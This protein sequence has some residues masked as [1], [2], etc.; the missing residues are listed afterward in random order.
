[1]IQEEEKE[2]VR[3]RFL[4]FKNAEVT[5]CVGLAPGKPDLKLVPPQTTPIFDL[6]SQ[7]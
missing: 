4:Q 1:M 5:K 6:K 2:S 7:A 3:H